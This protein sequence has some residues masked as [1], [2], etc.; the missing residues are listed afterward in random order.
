[1]IG[2]SQTLNSHLELTCFMF[3]N[4]SGIQVVFEKFIT[5][6]GSGLL[7]LRGLR[8]ERNGTIIE[9]SPLYVV[10]PRSETLHIVAIRAE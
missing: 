10:F 5:T 6:T 1:M 8:F 7:P 2:F 4:Y 3:G 9:L